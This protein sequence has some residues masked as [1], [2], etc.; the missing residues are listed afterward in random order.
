MRDEA[1]SSEAAAPVGDAAEL[2]VDAAQPTT[3]L[4]IRL[5]DGSRKVVKANHTHTVLQLTQH[6]ATLSPPG[7]AFT[8]RAGFPPKPLTAMDQ[9]LKEAGL[10]NEAITQSMS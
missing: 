3:T 4:Q 6:V 1:A 8:L 7:A 9:T 5:S 10:L 2:T